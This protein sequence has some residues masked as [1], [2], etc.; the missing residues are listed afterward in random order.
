MEWRSHIK[1]WEFLPFV[2]IIKID[3][4]NLLWSIT[5]E[6]GETKS[7]AKTL[8]K[9]YWWIAFMHIFKLQRLMKTKYKWLRMKTSHVYFKDCSKYLSSGLWK[10]K[11]KGEKK[12]K[13][14][15]RWAAWRR[16]LEREVV[17]KFSAAT[18]I[19]MYWNAKQVE[20]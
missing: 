6:T 1:V 7:R 8:G 19:R 5:D 12:R 2:M 10:E 3:T 11:G 20:K 18:F 14:E 13:G 15:E 16:F 4:R 17:R 9:H